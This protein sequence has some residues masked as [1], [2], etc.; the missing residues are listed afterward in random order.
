[1]DEHRARRAEYSTRCTTCFAM[2]RWQTEPSGLQRLQQRTS[3][4]SV[5][6]RASALANRVLEWGRNLTGG[7]HRILWGDDRCRC[8][9]RTHFE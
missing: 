2:A 9:L 5:T 1:M 7:L 6:E 4:Y 8:Y 3:G